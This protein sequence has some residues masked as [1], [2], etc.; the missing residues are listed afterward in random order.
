MS[1]LV[2]VARFWDAPEM[3]A[4]LGALRSAGFHPWASEFFHATVN[5]AIFVGLGGVRL[6]VP[7]QEAEAAAELIR[8]CRNGKG[9]GDHGEAI[10]ASDRDDGLL[11]PACGKGDYF[12]LKSWYQSWAFTLYFGA[13]TALATG[14]LLCRS[15]G[16][17]WR[18]AEKAA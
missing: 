14:R 4:A 18:P 12:R 1:R 7:E 16:H 10:R 11:C 9:A 13:P 15:C 5:P 2:T 8:T 3:Y 17:K 6:H